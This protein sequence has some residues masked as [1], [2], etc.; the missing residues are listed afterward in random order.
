MAARARRQVTKE[1]GAL[2]ME[3]RLVN[4][5][6]NKGRHAVSRHYKQLLVLAICWAASPSAGFAASLCEDRAE[7]LAR[8]LLAEGR[9]C[10][11][12]L[13]RQFQRRQDV[14]R[15]FAE[16]LV[17]AAL[18]TSIDDLQASSLSLPPYNWSR[19][20][21]L[22]V[23]LDNDDLMHPYL[24][25]YF[26]TPGSANEARPAGLGRLYIERGPELLELVRVRS[27]SEKE[28]FS[29]GVAGGVASLLYPYLTEENFKRR[30]VGAHWEL[31]R[32]DH[33]DHELVRAIE[34]EVLNRIR[35]QFPL[36]TLRR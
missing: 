1:R 34:L 7:A 22:I 14:D 8:P 27:V 20:A 36:R 18:S 19:I 15:D 25:F 4:S 17:R 3:T 10:V 28:E 2:D 12:Y 21:T 11:T 9:E 30:I 26:R 33:P 31:L 29:R 23:L 35:R 13:I 5:F 16:A 32:P 24:E 6:I